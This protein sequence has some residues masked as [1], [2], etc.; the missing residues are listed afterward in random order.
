MSGLLGRSVDD[1]VG[2][3][4][5]VA[6]VGATSLLCPLPGVMVNAKASGVCAGSACRSHHVRRSISS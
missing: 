2:V 4:Q 1:D 3:L 6:V 5:Q